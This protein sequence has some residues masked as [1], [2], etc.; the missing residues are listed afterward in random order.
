MPYLETEEEA[1]ENIADIHEHKNNTRKKDY[2]RKKESNFNKHDMDKNGYN[3]NGVDKNGLDRN[4]Y[5]I[6]GV[7]KNEI[8][9][10]GL[11]INGIKGTKKRYP[12]KILIIKKMIMV[13][14]MIGM[15]L[16]QLDLIKM[17]MTYMDLIYMDLIKMVMTYMDLIKMD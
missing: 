5:N 17:V 13:F 15:D 12:K 7:D 16:I 11:N 3:I 8:N 4:G 6:N 1:A 10:N 9:R 14:C 2:T